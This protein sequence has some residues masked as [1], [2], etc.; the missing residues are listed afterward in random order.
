MRSIVSIFIKFT[1]YQC[2]FSTQKRFKKHRIQLEPSKHSCEYIKDI[3]NI[4]LIPNLNL[5][6]N[7]I[8]KKLIWFLKSIQYITIFI[9]DD[10]KLASDKG[11]RHGALLI[12]L[13]KDFNGLHHDLL[14]AKLHSYVFDI[15][16]LKMLHNYFTNRKQ[17]VKIDRTF[18]FWEE[19]LIDVPQISILGWLLF[20][21]FYGIYFFS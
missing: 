12:D 21:I 17:R 20:N 5:L 19:I 3:W 7:N 4:Y 11:G 2:N 6:W 15:Q 18:S 9:G 8:V 14:I 10:R 16:V 13:S 1:Q